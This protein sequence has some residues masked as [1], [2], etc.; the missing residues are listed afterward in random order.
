M[1]KAR[2]PYHIIMSVGVFC[3]LSGL[4]C[5]QTEDE[6]NVVEA[7]VVNGDTIPMVVLD[8]F[9]IQESRYRRSKRYQR[10][11]GRIK[12]KVMKA[13]PYAKVTEELL[14][15]YEEELSSL[16][17]RKDRKVYLDLAE[18][19]LKEEF[20]GEIR[21]LTVSE[22]KILIK[23]IDRQ[24]D[25]TSYALIKDLKGGFSAFMWQSVAKFFGTDLKA[26]YDPKGDDRI[27]EEIVQQIESGDIY[28]PPRAAV[29]TKAQRR[30]EKKRKRRQRKLSRE[31]EKRESTVQ[32]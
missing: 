25:K 17:E 6:T 19:E 31:L 26:Q 10:R 9:S 27:I 8:E 14:D 23:L 1:L 5:A 13:Y 20:E 12:K 29:T 7:R 21:N 28:V 16:D 32:N 24:T 15:N 4:L 2:I 30:L 3:L 22:G 11:Y 18:K